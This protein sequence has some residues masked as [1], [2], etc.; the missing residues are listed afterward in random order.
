M[1]R[2]PQRALDT[3][4]GVV[5][6]VRYWNAD[7]GFTVLV[8][9]VADREEIVVGERETGVEKGAKFVAHGRWSAHPK[10]GRQFGFEALEVL[11]PST[12]EQVIARLKT[13][14]GIGQSTAERIVEQLG[15]RTWEI[16]DRD[17]EV[18]EHIPGIGPAA[19]RKIKEH[20]RKQSGALAKLRNRLIELGLAPGLAKAIHEE[21]G[22]YS[23]QMLDDYPYRV[24][25]KVSRV[26][27]AHAEKIARATGIDRRN[28]DRVDAGVVDELRAALR[29][30]GDCC[31]PGPEL[32]GRSARKLGLDEDH[33]DAGIERLLEHG[34]LEL[35]SGMVFLGGVD[36]LEQRV[37]DAISML[38]KSAR[39]VLFTGT[40]GNDLAEGQR[41]AV[42]MVARSGVTVLTGGP[43]TGKSRTVAAVLDLARSAG[44][45][46]HLCAPTG[47]AARRLTEATGKTASTIHRLLRPTPGGGFHHGSAHPLP[48]GLVVVDEMSMVD[49]DLADALLS[50]LDER[51]RLL[52]VGDV[53]QL[54]AVGAG[55][56]LRDIISAAEAGANISVVRLTEVFRQE[57]GSTIVDNAHRLLRGEDLVSDPSSRG[58]GGQFYIIPCAE[59]KQAQR[60]IVHLAASRIPAAYD[61]DPAEEVQILC[62]THKGDAGV[63][64]FNARLQQTYNRNQPAFYGA[65]GRRFCVGDRVMQM[66]NDYER[67][68]FNGDVGFVA[69]IAEKEVA[70]DFDGS[71]K[72]YKRYDS[73][74]LQLA[75][76]MTIHKSQGGEFPAVIIPVFRSRMLDRQLLYTAITRARRLCV[77]VG[78]VEEIR[79]AVRA[80]S[81]RRCTRLAE[82]LTPTREDH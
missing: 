34:A 78:R 20:H 65:Q 66:R 28:H 55:D 1:N 31:L 24:A 21:F 53:D 41:A 62:P 19:L 8:T 80:E 6:T 12:T 11:P 14:P 7:S 26:S 37:A 47:R 17:I 42:E 60:K 25:R 52:L 69:R 3:I 58:A 30:D 16:L 22:E 51:H 64:A 50:A 4:E 48:P 81:R 71:V 49:L 45:D 33:V 73:R 39:V 70:V 35:H 75:Y 43:G 27:F 68:V 63:E 10:H 5:E 59:P 36:R 15:E 2:R 82:R 56:V 61:L 76:A 23:V 13:Y 9:T 77:I 54:P 79:R 40:V 72:T 67:N 57:D 29:G 38:A 18:L 32:S 44:I 46:V 74:A